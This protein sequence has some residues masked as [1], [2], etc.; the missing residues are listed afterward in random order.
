[1]LNWEI[2][3]KPA[4][5]SPHGA[6]PNSLI[7]GGGGDVEWGKVIFDRECK[8]QGSCMKDRNFLT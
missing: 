6:P 7:D 4:G 2:H 8:P 5:T 1:M 3:H